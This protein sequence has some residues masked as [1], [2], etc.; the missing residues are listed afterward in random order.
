[1]VVM[2]VTATSHMAQG[3]ISQGGSIVLMVVKDMSQNGQNWLIVIYE[4]KT[5]RAEESNLESKM[6]LMLMVVL[7]VAKVT[8]HISHGGSIVK[9]KSLK[10]RNWLI[11]I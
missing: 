6:V 4:T 9:E 10:G 5:R 1:M 11:V 2:V 7:M 8:S 3:D